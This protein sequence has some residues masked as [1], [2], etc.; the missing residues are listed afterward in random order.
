MPT[1]ETL[2]TFWKVKVVTKEVR[3]IFP[4]EILGNVLLWSNTAVCCQSYPYLI[5]QPIMQHL[6]A[7]VNGI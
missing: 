5:M 6:K 1:T 2:H 4:P 7:A 3:I